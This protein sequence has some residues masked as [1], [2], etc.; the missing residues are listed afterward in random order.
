MPTKNRTT[1]ARDRHGFKVYLSNDARTWLKE[2][3][4]SGKGGK[5]VPA[6]VREVI[7][8]AMNRKGF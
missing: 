8:K 2:H 4:A 7:E 1:T 5:H 3:T 6:Q